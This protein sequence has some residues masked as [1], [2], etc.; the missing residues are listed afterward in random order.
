M[1]RTRIQSLCIGAS[2]LFA[3]SLTA[4]ADIKFSE[5]FMYDPGA[6]LDGQNGGTGFQ[7]PWVQGGSDLDLIQGGSLTYP[8]YA[9]AGNSVLQTPPQDFNSTPFRD[10]NTISGGQGGPN[11][12]LYVSYLVKKISDSPQSTTPTPAEDY[13]G[14]VLYGPPGQN[15]GILI[16]D[17]SES[18]NF[19]LGTAGS[20][21][22]GA[23]ISGKTVTI[24]ETALLIAK[25]DFSG[26][27]DTI[28]LFVNPDLSLPLG[29]PDAIKTDVDLQNIQ[30]I[31]FVGGYGTYQYDEIRAS[32]TLSE[33]LT[34][35]GINN[36]VPDSP[37]SAAW[38][39]LPCFASAMIRRFRARQS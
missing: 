15:N 3:F 27:N 4:K 25:I 17:P 14:L 10:V 36:N 29:A 6:T 18:S 30:A 38:V 19:S 20:P 1:K 12:P 13:F 33:L 11:N 7:N 24:G 8:G 39:L 35:E 21:S 22:T 32:T 5:S 2:A 9:S 23:E 37:V 26:G 16:G 34:P 28:S 31:G